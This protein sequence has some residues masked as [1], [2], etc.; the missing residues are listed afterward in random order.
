[1]RILHVEPRRYG[2]ELRAQL[3]AA[4]QVDYVECATHDDY[5]TA[6]AAAPY[7]AVFVRLGVRT[8][9]SALAAAPALRFVVTPT[10]GLDHVDVTAAEARGITVISLR[11]ETEFLATI[12]STAEHTW[13]LLLALVR[14]LPAAVEDVKQGRWRREPFLADELDGATLGIL[15]YGRLGRIVAGYG[16]AFGM[17]VLAHDI[18]AA[19]VAAAPPPV[20]AVGLDRLLAESDVLS[21]HLPLDASTRGFLSAAR[22]AAMKPGAYLVNTARG[23]LV[24]EPALL[25]ALATGTLAGAA[26]DVLAGDG[27]WGEDALPADHALLRF[28]R[29]HDTLLIS[30][31]VGGYGLHSI[32]RTRAF[33]TEGFL[34]TAGRKGGPP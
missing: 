12:K 1:M 16:V 7:E 23:E 22:I 3:A 26:L 5:L 17:R 2:S 20:Q 18:D 15:G 33:V 24:D 28:A 21:V 27:G 29:Q 31:H 19:A 25:A 9:A 30:P 13:A 11:G 4:G 8:D 32:N 6:L 10:T 14:R 34:R